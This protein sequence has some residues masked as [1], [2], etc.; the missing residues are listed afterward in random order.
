M[1][2]LLPLVLGLQ[3][4]MA[5]PIS[6][7]EPLAPLEWDASAMGTW[8]RF[9]LNQHLHSFRHGRASVVLHEIYAVNTGWTYGLPIAEECILDAPPVGCAWPMDSSA[10][11]TRGEQGWRVDQARPRWLH[12]L[13]VEADAYFSL[14]S[15]G[16]FMGRYRP[17][18]VNQAISA[19]ARVDV[20]AVL[21]RVRATERRGWSSTLRVGPTFGYQL[22]AVSASGVWLPVGTV[23]AA[24]QAGRRVPLGDLRRAGGFTPG[25]FEFHL[26]AELTADRAGWKDWITPE[27]RLR[28]TPVAGA[29]AGVPDQ[30]R[31]WV[32]EIT[33]QLVAMFL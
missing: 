20:D 23:L 6:V 10:V 2:A 31:A 32:H 33:F 24:R 8:A 26:E 18:T 1:S 30:D 16:P 17:Y 12:D 4:A 13:A 28:R 27:L 7:R 22:G 21:L 29:I 11:L 19:G 15:V 3:A 25:A 14:P 5:A 9:Q